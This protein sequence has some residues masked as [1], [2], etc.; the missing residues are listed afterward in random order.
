MKEYDTLILSYGLT[1]YQ[2]QVIN[3]T[4]S[5]DFVHV[6]CDNEFETLLYV[7][8]VCVAINTDA[9]NPAQRKALNTRLSDSDNRV[10][11]ILS[12]TAK[13]RFNFAYH[14]DLLDK[15]RSFEKYYRVLRNRICDNFM[16][17]S[18]GPSLNDGFVVMDIETSGADPDKDEIIRI[19][20]VRVVDY[21]K[22]DRFER[23]IRPERLLSPEI[24][25]LTGISNESLA[26]CPSI[27]NVLEEFLNWHK[28]DLLTVYDREFDI[29]FLEKACKR[30]GINLDRPNLDVLCVVNKLYPNI[31]RCKSGVAFNALKLSANSE[32]YVDMIAEIWIACLHRLKMLGVRATW[33]IDDVDIYRF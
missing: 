17:D 15:A 10:M 3:Q 1:K 32:E 19:S 9:M 28:H 33:G 12:G 30:C 16:T 7:T 8:A 11:I 22:A 2:K 18:H 21:D 6:V 25:K 14:K 5:P 4:I 23:L 27:K 29:S 13:H 24:E 26:E 31:V 20:A